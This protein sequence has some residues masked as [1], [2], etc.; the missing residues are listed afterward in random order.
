ML[1]N[2]N[3]WIER[4]WL[5]I[6]TRSS[7][8]AASRLAPIP[9]EAAVDPISACSAGANEWAEVCAGPDETAPIE[10]EG[11]RRRGEA[12]ESPFLAEQ[13]PAGADP[14]RRTALVVSGP[15]ASLPDPIRARHGGFRAPSARGARKLSE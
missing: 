9:G 11:Q 5:L 1:L 12:R 13:Q 10:H 8:G 2:T 4:K 14:H 6:R 7:V 3:S 15:P